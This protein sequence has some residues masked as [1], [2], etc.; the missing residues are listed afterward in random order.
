MKKPRTGGSGAS[1]VPRGLGIAIS[2]CNYKK[3]R[4]SE[5]P[6]GL[7]A[8]SGGLGVSQSCEFTS[9]TVALP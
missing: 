6:P 1:R 5:R 2:E 9:D 7:L 3:P 4:R 8:R